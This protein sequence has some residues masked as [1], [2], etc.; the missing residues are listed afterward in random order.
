MRA[1]SDLYIKIQLGE[2]LC[3]LLQRKLL[4][5][6]CCFS[7]PRCL[8]LQVL[9]RC[10]QQRMTLSGLCRFSHWNLNLKKTTK[11]AVLV[12]YRCH[13]EVSIMTPDRKSTRLNSSHVS[14]SYA[15]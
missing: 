13:T 15:V 5:C 2:Q 10:L 14:I 8:S 12:S 9:A 6:F 4:V 1:R 11:S 3:V 7:A